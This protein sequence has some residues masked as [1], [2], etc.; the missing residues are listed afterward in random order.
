MLTERV[1]AVKPSMTLAVIAKVRQLKASGVKVFDFGAGE[2]DFNT[3]DYIKEAAVAALKDNFTRY[4]AASGIIE[5]REAIAR[6]ISSDNQLEYSPDQILITNGAKQ[7]IYNGLQALAQEG[8]E[9]I[10]PAPYWVSFPEM[11]VL[12]GAKPVIVEGSEENEFRLTAGQLEKALTP[13]TKAFIM[14]SPQN[15][16][17]TVY[18]RDE[19]E[20]LA[21]VFIERNIFVISDEVY[22]KLRY[23]PEPHASIA[24]VSPEMK[25][26]TL[27]V[28]S[29]SKTYAM[30]GWRIGF[31]AG[32]KELISAMAKVQSQ[33]TS[34]VSSITQKAALAALSSGDEIIAERTEEFRKRRDF[35]VKRINS[36][37]GL[38]CFMPG[39]A[40]FL[41]FSI[42]DFVGKTF[43]ETKVTGSIEFATVLLEQKHVAVVPGIGFGA[44]NYIRLSYATSMEDIKEGLD[45]LE[46]FLASA[47]I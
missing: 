38:S 43:G 32:P 1:K 25:E 46:E 10:I 17:G 13:N 44:E 4:T 12:A 39:G 28:N 5:L 42:G 23:N 3:A 9:V 36:I 8:D 21:R 30:T 16:T 29:L 27:L 22:D 7:S 33:S 24:Q 37:D 31:C 47:G 2:P 18:S 40:F 26:R 11:V 15:P 45:L 41:F 20:A 35:T 6:R 34:G 19:L 14:N